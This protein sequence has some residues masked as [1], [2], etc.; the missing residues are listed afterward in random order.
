MSL[1]KLFVAAFAVATVFLFSACD[2][3]E[4][5]VVTFNQALVERDADSL[6]TVIYF[7]KDRRDER[8]RRKQT[9]A[10][11]ALDYID[12][13]RGDV[14]QVEKYKTMEVIGSRISGDNAVVLVCYKPQWLEN[15][16]GTAKKNI[17]LFICKKDGDQWKVDKY[18]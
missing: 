11:W 2:S 17:Q 7:D 8:N 5:A 3:P 15:V 4:S 12:K 9:D 6:S 18:K 13:E 14:V 1:N 16:P 10:E